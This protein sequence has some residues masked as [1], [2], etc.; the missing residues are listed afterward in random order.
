MREH[1]ARLRADLPTGP[2]RRSTAAGT[3]RAVPSRRRHPAFRRRSLAPLPTRLPCTMDAAGL[4]RAFTGFFA[5]R[6]HTVV[7]SAG[8]IPHHPSAPMFTNSGMMPFVPVLPRRGAGAVVTRP[9]HLGAEVRAGRRQAQR[10]RRHRPLAAPPQ[11]LRDARQLQ[12]RR[13]LQGRRHPVG[14]GV[15]H[16]GARPRPRP[17]LGHRPRRP[18]TRPSRSGPTRSASPRERIQRLDKDNFWEMGETGPCGPCSEIF[19]D[20]GPELGP[21]GGPANPARREPLRRDLEPGLPAVLPPRRRHRSPTCRSQ[22]I[23]TG[24]GL[25]RILA[26]LAG[27]P[28]ALRHRHAARCWSTRRSRSPAARSA[29]TPSHRRG[30]ARC[31]PTTPAP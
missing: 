28:V 17:A 27:Q 21:D 22:N 9:G 1:E 6:D 10:P 5:D 13:L 26:V 11:L 4:R 25:E 19:F 24:A 2:R 7:P 31:S 29:T 14:L 12:L 16:R 8:L 30:A 3:L 23:D 18:T 15:R 20:Y